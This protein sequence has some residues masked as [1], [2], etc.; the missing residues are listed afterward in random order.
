MVRRFSF[1]SQDLHCDFFNKMKLFALPE[2]TPA[3]TP[4]SSNPQLPKVVAE[5]FIAE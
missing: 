3:V 1:S 5:G 4:K 2:T